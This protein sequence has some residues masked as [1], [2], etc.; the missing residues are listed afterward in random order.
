MIRDGLPVVDKGDGAWTIGKQP[1]H[2]S[3]HVGTSLGLPG[4]INLGKI[5]LL[6]CFQCIHAMPAS[7]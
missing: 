7:A 5:F 2:L 1:S 6:I 4:E 3:E